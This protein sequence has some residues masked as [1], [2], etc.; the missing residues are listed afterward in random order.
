MRHFIR[1]TQIGLS[2]LLVGLVLSACGMQRPTAPATPT[3][4]TIPLK[5]TETT[6]PTVTYSPTPKPTVRIGLA[7]TPHLKPT[8]DPTILPSKL[9]TEL[10]FISEPGINDHSV[11][12][13]TGWAYGFATPYEFYGRRYSEPVSWL[14]DGHVLLQPVTGESWGRGV[15]QQVQPA[16]ASLA[17]DR[18]WLLPT[19]WSS[20]LF[21]SAV[22]SELIV[23]EKNGFSLYDPDGHVLH[24]TESDGRYYYLSPSG[25]R[26]LA[27]SQTG[28]T[29]YDLKTNQVVNIE[30]KNNPGSVGWSPDETRLFD[31]DLCQ[32][33]AHVGK[34]TCMNFKLGVFGG[35]GISTIYWVPGDKVMLDWP[36]FFE[37][38]PVPDNPGIVLLIDPINRSYQ[39]VRTLAGFDKRTA[40]SFTWNSPFPADRNHVWLLCDQKPYV[41]DLR[42]FNKQAVP[43][44]LEFVSWS[45]DSKFALT[46]QLDQNCCEK[47]YRY[48]MYS[49]ATTEAYSVTSSA[50]L[51]PTWSTT[52]SRLAYLAEDRQQLGVL[53][54]ATR[55]VV[56][57]FLP[58]PVVNIYWHPQNHGLAVQADDNSLWWIAD[59]SVNRIEKLTAPLPEVRDVKWSP[60]G[61]KLAFVSGSDVY[62]VTVSK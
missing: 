29:W 20:D 2:L 31:E 17:N 58:Q 45:P 7:P 53:D 3:A 54:A 6:L 19:R 49:L 44:D 16:V 37:G 5:A 36:S 59:P 32:I 30:A 50:I 27:V 39:D 15:S 56:M 48:A 8:I 4:S 1:C 18:F 42:T 11:Q 34:I 47:P 55:D 25:Q 60:S 13:I 24:N 62:V 57:H 9:M 28:D 21:W 33:D 61:D 38:T 52:G 41:I 40:C 14:D 26:L 22:L 51:S 10:K 46:Q 35:E 12:R 43:T 23:I